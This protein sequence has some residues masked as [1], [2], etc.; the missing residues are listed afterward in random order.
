MSKGYEDLSRRALIKLGKDYDQEHDAEL[1]N[2][3]TEHSD[4]YENIRVLERVMVATDRVAESLKGSGSIVKKALAKEGGK[5]LNSII[6]AVTVASSEAE[7]GLT[8][9]KDKM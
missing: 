1:L 6:D 7:K 3:L 9:L 5:V 8:A 4:D 2:Y